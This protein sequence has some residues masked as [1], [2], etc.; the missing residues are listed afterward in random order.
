MT[1]SL[2]GLLPPQ[3]LSTPRYCVASFAPFVSNT[4]V[5]AGF[6]MYFIWRLPGSEWAEANLLRKRTLG[7]TSAEG[8]LKRGEG[9][10]VGE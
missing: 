5:E 3:I 4:Q 8:R 2:N 1:D 7:E 10:V 9:I 6:R